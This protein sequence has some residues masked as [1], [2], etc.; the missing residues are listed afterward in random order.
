MACVDDES[1][2][3][4]I[5]PGM[6]TARA[7]ARCP[8]LSILEV[9]P[10]AEESAMAWLIALGFGISPRVEATEPGQ[11]T[12]DLRGTGDW[13]DIG[14]RAIEQSQVTGLPIRIGLSST[15]ARATWASF[16]P[17]A[18]YRAET[19][20]ELFGGLSPEEVPLP[21]ELRQ[22]LQEWGIRDLLTFA[23]FSKEDVGRRLG[24]ETVVFWEEMKGRRSRLLRVVP[25]VPVF[26]SEMEL[27][28]RVE[29]LEQALFVIRR[30]LSEV[31]SSLLAAGRVARSLELN[32]RTE[33][34]A[35]GG[36]SFQLPEATARID[37]IFAMIESYLSGV[38]TDKAL[39]WIG[40][41]AA[42][43]DPLPEQRDFFEI[44]TT[45]PFSFQETIGR[46]HGLLGEQ[47]V[48]VPVSGES[49]HPDHF[50]IDPPPP[51]FRV[52]E[53]AAPYAEPCGPALRR[54]RPARAVQVWCRDRVPIRCLWR[55]RSHAVRAVRGPWRISG[56]W[57][58]PRYRWSQEEWDV[59]WGQGCYCRL[60]RNPAG[61]W[62]WEGV[63]D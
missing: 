43:G 17:R 48:G 5:T 9:D 26:R 3:E 19:D 30:L 33:S 22:S 24:P 58:D 14:R 35:E 37:P 18:F 31:C 6:S 40:L 55:K 21:K 41:E 15:P 57:W 13:E 4:G 50:R 52:S 7:L 45:S 20:E 23:R 47:T 25:G 63:Y 39:Q 12:V 34:D 2:I 60:M 53:E 29:T 10:A 56:D 49:H 51:Q 59:E 36:H 54:F 8:R 44:S 61:E 42:A 16:G 38:R 46:I 62:F 27:E 11:V 32:W 1:R 28:H